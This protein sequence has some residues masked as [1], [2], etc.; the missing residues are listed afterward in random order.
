V[1]YDDIVVHCKAFVRNPSIS[2]LPSNQS[3]YFTH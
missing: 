1:R 3:E 2:Q